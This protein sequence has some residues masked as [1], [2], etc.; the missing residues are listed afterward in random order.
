LLLFTVTF[1]AAVVIVVPMTVNLPPLVLAVNS[2]TVFTLKF[3]TR[4]LFVR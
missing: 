1:V 4:V 3:S 2:F